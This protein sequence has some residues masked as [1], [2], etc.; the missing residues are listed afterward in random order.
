MGSVVA[1]PQSHAIAVPIGWSK[2]F[3]EEKIFD[4]LDKTEYGGVVVQRT[5]AGETV[6]MQA[7]GRCGR[8]EGEEDS[9]SGF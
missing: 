3:L 8:A 2:A 1:F 4:G 6:M 7:L 9:E 5:D